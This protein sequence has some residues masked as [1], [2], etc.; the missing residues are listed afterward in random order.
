MKKFRNVSFIVFMLLMLVI[1][2]CGGGGD[3]ASTDG[4]KEKKGNENDNVLTI[5]TSADMVS[6][7]VHN[8][9]ATQTQAIHVNMFDSLLEKD[10]DGNFVADLADSWKNID[11]LTWEFTLNPKAT[12][13]NGDPV[14]SNDVKFTLERAAKDETLLENKYFKQIK[15]IKIIDDHKFQIITNGPDPVL[16][17]RI[18]R[19]GSGILPAK[20]IEENGWEHFLKNPI[21]AGP[22]KFVEWKKDDRLTLAKYENYYKYD[23]K[24][25]KVVFRVIP[26]DSTRV[27][28]LLTGGI[29]MAVNI[30]P[31]DWDRI[32]DNEGTQVISGPTQRIMQLVMRMTD[33]N[34][35]A[36]PL[37]R[38][39]VEL[40]IDKQLIVDTLY[41]G[42]GTITRTGVTPIATGGNEKLFGQ[43]IYDPEKAKKLL[44]EA[45]YENGVDITLSVSNGRY[46]KDKESAEL[47]Q[48]MLAEVGINATLE[49]FEWSKFMELYTGKTF[50]E[51]YLIGYANSLN[52]A[53]NPLGL[54]ES[55]VTK[56][57]TDYNNPEV[58]K[59]LNDAMYNMNPEERAEQYKKVQEIVA[60]DRPRIYLYTLDQFIGIKDNLTYEPHIDEWYIVDEIEKVK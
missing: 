3:K 25:E 36:D 33:G 35:T 6:F 40:A 16:L 41:G 37:V 53:S 60:N 5:G 54:V 44:K 9:Q 23:P 43:D 34:A 45:G 11:E 38:E 31:T 49:P 2:G 10:R 15:E 39:A 14:T 18:S 20:Y 29:D 55:K 52:D 56:G 32:N 51:I 42:S 7:D 48:S 50:K 19:Q 4:S 26:E 8:H 1:T 13:H 58:D 24:W 22:Y 28:E 57:E 17:N 46:L 30:A 59:L 21:G 12:F 47:I 27:A